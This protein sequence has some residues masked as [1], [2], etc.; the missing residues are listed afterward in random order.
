MTM[1]L[2]PRARRGGMTYAVALGI[3]FLCASCIEGDMSS[4]GTRPLGVGVNRPHY[5]GG[6]FLH[7]GN[8]PSTRLSPHAR[9]KNADMD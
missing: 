8:H 1:N 3:V 4:E 6:G 5:R 9:S 7:E 2:P